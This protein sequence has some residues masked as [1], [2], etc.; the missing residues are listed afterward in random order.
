MENFIGDNIKAFRINKGYSQDQLAEI[1]GVSQSAVS[2]WEC[3]DSKPHMSN[4]Q[5]I[6]DAFPELVAD[7][8]LSDELGYAKKVLQKPNQRFRSN[9]KNKNAQKKD[10]Q[11]ETRISTHNNR[12]N[13]SEST[14]WNEAKSGDMVDVPLF[15][16]IAAGKP[17]EMLAS[18]ETSPIPSSIHKRHPKAFLLKVEGESMNRVLPNGC[19]ALIDPTLQEVHEGKVYAVCVDDSSAT[20]KRIHLLNNGVELQPDSLDPAFKP[21]V[22]DY[23][24]NQSHTLTILGQAVWYSVPYGFEL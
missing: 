10:A 24:N 9:A 4:V 1:A 11:K 15:G 17:L 6:V 19:Y 14:S 5:R 16:S 3:G 8:I 13:A 22:F 20:I 7:D 18:E 2:A 23:K 21:S 12:E